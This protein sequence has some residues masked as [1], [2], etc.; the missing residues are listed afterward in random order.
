MSRASKG[1]EL[2][3]DLLLDGEEVLA[4]IPATQC[5]PPQGKSGTVSG[6][7]ALTSGRVLFSGKAIAKRRTRAIPLDT[8]TSIEL[9]K[10]AMLSHVQLTLAGSYENFLVKYK[11]AGSVLAEA[12]AALAGGHSPTSAPQAPPSSVADE[13]GKLAELHEKGLLS[14]EEFAAA[15]ARLL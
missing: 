2:L 1:L 10:G 4:S 11:E 12:Q 8:I 13:I 7:L 6:V 9:I 14:D 5:D 15:K 3:S